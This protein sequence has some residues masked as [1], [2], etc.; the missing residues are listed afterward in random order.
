MYVYMFF[1]KTETKI[2]VK[3]LQLVFLELSGYFLKVLCALRRFY[4]LYVSE[5]PL[6]WS[7]YRLRLCRKDMKKKKTLNSLIVL[8]IQKEHV[9]R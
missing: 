1:K 3:S 2:N 8:S 6:L 5:T 7:H 9:T 4:P